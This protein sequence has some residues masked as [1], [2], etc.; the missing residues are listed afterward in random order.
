MGASLAAKLQWPRV[1]ILRPRNPAIHPRQLFQS[2][3]DHHLCQCKTKN[4][5]NQTEKKQT[6]VQNITL[7]VVWSF[8][9]DIWWFHPKRC[10]NNLWHGQVLASSPTQNHTNTGIHTWFDIQKLEP[11]NLDSGSSA[12]SS[13]THEDVVTY[14]LLNIDGFYNPRK[15]QLKTKKPTTNIIGKMVVPLGWYPSSLSP[16]RT[17][18]K[19]IY[20][21]NTH[22]I[23]CIWG[24]LLRVPSQGYHHFP[25]DSRDIPR[26][27]LYMAYGKN[28][29]ISQQS[30]PWKKPL[31]LN[32]CKKNLGNWNH[33]IHVWH[34][35]LNLP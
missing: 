20:R 1:D 34:I 7:I 25:Y 13:P 3:R 12:G 19:G 24:W 15:P 8:L 26:L 21:I 28:H 11:K 31:M 5:I 27:Y 30:S 35:Y 9:F 32:I 6:T 23:S 18:F 14:L 29:Q 2:H 4:N 16:P 10:Q 33:R 17:P 22:Y